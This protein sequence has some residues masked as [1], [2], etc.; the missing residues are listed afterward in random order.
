MI[1][2]GIFAMIIGSRAIG[3]RNFMVTDLGENPGIYFERAEDIYFTKATW[4][5][6]IA[7]DLEHAEFHEEYYKE[8]LKNISDTC[9]D[10]V[11]PGQCKGI[12]RTFA[13][14]NTRITDLRREYEQ[15]REGLED[16]E[17]SHEELNEP[18][19][20]LSK[21]A[22]LRVVG[23]IAKLLFG[24]LSQDDGER[25]QQQFKEMSQTERRLTSLAKEQTHLITKQLTRTEHQ[26]QV[27]KES[28][29]LQLERLN[30]TWQEISHL[31]K[32]W[33]ILAY[34]S[35]VQLIINEILLELEETRESYAL[36]RE[37]L[38]SA[39]LGQLHP[40][41]IKTTQLA[42]IID[43]VRRT[44][45]DL[46]FP[47]TVGQAKNGDLSKL[48]ETTVGYL[49]KQL[50]LRLSIPVIEKTPTEL[51]DIHEVPVAQGN[52]KTSANIA[53]NKRHMALSYDKRF[54][55][56]LTH[57][58]MERCIKLRSKQIC[59]HEGTWLDGNIHPDCEL[60]L[61]NQPSSE[62]IKRCP[63]TITKDFEGVWMHLRP[64]N[65]WLFSLP[66]QT[67]V[68]VACQTGMTE[69]VYLKGVGILKV[70]PGCTA[71]EGKFKMRSSPLGKKKYQ[72]HTLQGFR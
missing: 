32:G 3:E 57:R 37:I 5:V 54:Y 29:T 70:K 2:I 61:L 21:R 6:L 7:I 64:S 52:G 59:R 67:K 47:V 65:A 16:M 15:L 50:I 28:F 34:S 68:M 71:I 17:I 49:D 35:R 53:T 41:L 55:T 20:L 48:A 4:K 38:N 58:E 72:N 42:E 33:E 26:I 14:V 40:E 22:P 11:F 10:S 63:I 45:P 60:L 13:H 44:F 24:T 69:G 8:M 62:N 27:I 46:E 66:G 9:S 51:Y 39:K 12:Y 56:Y 1:L 25:I 30:E 18:G 23:A 36:T 43:D 19:R 31:T